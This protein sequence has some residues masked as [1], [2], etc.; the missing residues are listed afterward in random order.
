MENEVAREEAG[1]AQRSDDA[2][3][4]Q[5]SHEMPAHGQ[6]MDEDRGDNGNNALR[7]IAE[8]LNLDLSIDTFGIGGGAGTGGE[9]D[10][11]VDDRVANLQPADAR[12]TVAST[13]MLLQTTDRLQQTPELLLLS[14]AAAVVGGGSPALHATMNPSGQTGNIFSSSFS[15][16]DPISMISFPPMPSPP[17]NMLPQNPT[18][19]HD[20]ISSR[21]NP[22]PSLAKNQFPSA[23]ASLSL[24]KTRDI[25]TAASTSG[26]PKRKRD[27]L[28][29]HEGAAVADPD[30]NHDSVAGHHHFSSSLHLLD[31]SR[32]SFTGGGLADVPDDISVLDDCNV[33]TENITLDAECHRFYEVTNDGE[34]VRY[35][36]MAAHSDDVAV[37]RATRPFQPKEF[38]G[39]F[40]M[41]VVNA[42]SRDASTSIGLS[43]YLVPSNRHPG[44]YVSSFGYSNDGMKKC[45]G[46][47]H[48][49]GPKFA[50]GDTVGCGQNFSTGTVFFTLNGRHLGDAFTGVFQSLLPTVGLHGRSVVVNVNLGKHPF[51]FEK[52]DFARKTANME[53]ISAISIQPSEIQDLVRDYLIHN[54]YEDTYR[55]FTSKMGKR[56]SANGDNA[57]LMETLPIRKAVRMHIVNSRIVQAI[58]TINSNFPDFFTGL[59][60]DRNHHY[61]R[62]LLACEEF[63]ELSRQRGAE[64]VAQGSDRVPVKRRK[65][66]TVGALGSVLVDHS[67]EIVMAADEESLEYLKDILGPLHRHVLNGPDERQYIEDV[68]SLIAYNNPLLSPHNYLL[69]SE[70][71][72]SVADVLNYMVLA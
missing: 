19:L 5:P 45:E 27:D 44:S 12:S 9:G 63:I 65:V 67:A 49:Y 7:G 53:K 68:A 61:A 26:G 62:V 23:P 11:A 6:P 39:Y 1:R 64:A 24:V 32:L 50:A 38:V 10:P 60:R 69:T 56:I 18:T 14:A 22:F 20:I 29:D 43:N 16:D 48:S 8:D 47:S 2:T 35:T 40:E 59:P 41:T 70:H 34:T 30:L 33:E 36:G 31:A 57:I 3:H 13:S 58:D 72:K 51:R 21:Y 55:S 54:G 28:A 52:D 71:R 4:T 37:V 42:G 17:L 15:V 46:I 66:K 25:R